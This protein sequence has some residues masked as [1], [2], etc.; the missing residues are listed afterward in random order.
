M[1]IKHQSMKAIVSIDGNYVLTIFDNSG[2]LY[3]STELETLK[4]AQSDLR[5]VSIKIF[6]YMQMYR[7]NER[8]GINS[9]YVALFSDNRYRRD[10]FRNIKGFEVNSVSTVEGHFV[11][12]KSCDLE[13]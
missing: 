10:R 3:Q 9:E 6:D 4:T 5:I 12:C 1:A 8:N 2:V 11:V 13:S 7:E